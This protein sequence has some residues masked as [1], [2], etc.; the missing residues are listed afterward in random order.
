[1]NAPPSALA[2]DERSAT[3]LTR[4]LAAVL[5]CTLSG[6]AGFYLL[7]PTVP[8]YAV[9]ASGRQSAAGLV[10]GAL[11]ATTIAVQPAMP[12]VIAAL[13]YRAT[14]AA[15]LVLLGLPV[16]VLSA[17]ADLPLILACSALRGVGFGAFV[18]A[19]SAAVAELAPAGLRSRAAGWYGVATG[20]GGAV[21]TPFGVLLAHRFGHPPLFTAGALAPACGLLASLAIAAPRPAPVDRPRVVAGIARPAILRPFLLLTAGTMAVGAVVTFLPL[22]APR[23]PVWLT[24]AALL[25]FQLGLTGSRWLAGRLGDRY[26]NQVLLLPAVLITAVG[27]LGGV[28]ARNPAAL[29]ALLLLFGVGCGALQNA[30]L[31][32]MLHRAGRRGFSVAG[33]QWNLA[34]DVGLGLGGFCVGLV[35]QSTSYATGFVVVSAALLLVSCVALRDVRA[36]DGE[37]GRS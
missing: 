19:G 14:L 24:P 27:V 23:E 34:F 37:D 9:E 28:A 10:T 33:A 13:G 16:A 25:L 11:M 12:R 21:G 20:L 1:M 7:L 35:A 30:T 17:T 3:L 31:V 4:P 6:F 36:G 5:L 26:G 8:E 22:A 15:G 2:G 18:V 32:L 29:L